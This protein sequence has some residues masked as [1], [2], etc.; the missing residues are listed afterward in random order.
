LLEAADDM[1]EAGLPDKA[2]REKTTVR[3]R[4]PEATPKLAPITGARVR[5][6]CVSART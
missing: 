1:R 4:G 6:F 2:T 3:Y 5:K